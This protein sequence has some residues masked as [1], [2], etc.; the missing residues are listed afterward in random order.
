M[1]K[2]IYFV[3]I[4]IFIDLMFMLFI[5]MP[6]TSL[7]SVIFNSVVGLGAGELG[8]NETASYSYIQDNLIGQPDSISDAVNS[9]STAASSS[10][11]IGALLLGLGSVLVAGIVLK[12]TGAR[13]SALE[14]A[15]SCVGV[16]FF[17]QLG[18]DFVGVYNFLSQINPP[19]SKL[20]AIV[21]MVPIILIYSFICIEWIRAKD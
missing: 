18:A 11:L 4:L 2:L 12:F 7:N 21:L 8:A 6:E 5:N 17:V 10:T 14:I 9:P 20:M 16:F 19:L 3:G 1:G 13:V 15:W